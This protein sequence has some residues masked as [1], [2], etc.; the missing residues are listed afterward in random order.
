MKSAILVRGERWLIAGAVITAI[1]ALLHVAII[2]V[3][4]LYALSGAGVIRR[5]PSLR[6]ALSLVAAVFL[7]RGLLGVPVVLLVD[8]P[9]MNELK[10]KMAFMTLTS[11]V[12]VLLG[13]CYAIGAAS[14]RKRLE[15]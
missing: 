9:Y 4:G 12:C 15:R 10:G 8:D 11:L 3:V 14:I 13:A 5:L 6:L 7:A 1:A 2:G